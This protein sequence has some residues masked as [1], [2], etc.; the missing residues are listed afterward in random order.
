M[1][2]TEVAASEISTAAEVPA[3]AGVA[4]PAEVSSSGVPT[5]A[6]ATSGMAPAATA[7]DPVTGI[8][9][10]RR[11]G[12]R[13]TEQQDRG[14]S[15][16]TRCNCIHG[17]ITRLPGREASGTSEAFPTRSL[18]ARQASLFKLADIKRAHSLMR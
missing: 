2:A 17:F 11:C 5:S 16:H 15:H 18:D 4:A 12:H 9:Q 14:G 10:N 13:H 6:P 8:S 1:A 7:A 3:S